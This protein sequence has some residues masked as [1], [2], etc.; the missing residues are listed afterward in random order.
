[1]NVKDS[2]RQTTKHTHGPSFM[3]NTNYCL[4]E[5]VEGAGEIAQLV[6]VFAVQ[7][8]RPKFKPQNPCEKPSMM[9]Y[10]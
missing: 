7:A 2:G 1:M 5:R 3:K 4:R 10:A 9:A 8:R 6:E